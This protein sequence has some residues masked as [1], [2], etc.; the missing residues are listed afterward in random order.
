M[1]GGGDAGHVDCGE[2]RVTGTSGQEDGMLGNGVP[3]SQKDAGK[4]LTVSALKQL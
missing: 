3:E 4:D 1:T 2:I